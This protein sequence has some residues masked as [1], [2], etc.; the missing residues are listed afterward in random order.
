[1]AG[2]AVVYY[3]RA[4]CMVIHAILLMSILA[5]IIIIFRPAQMKQYILS[6]LDVQ[7]LSNTNAT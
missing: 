2:V 6:G 5:D 3:V 4:E 7:L 1:M